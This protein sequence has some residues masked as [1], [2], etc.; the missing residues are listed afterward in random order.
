MKTH[1]TIAGKSYTVSCS[2]ACEIKAQLGGELV[3]LATGEAGVQFCFVSPVGA[4]TSSSDKATLTVNFSA[5]A[6]GGSSQGGK[7]GAKAYM[8]VV[9]L[10]ASPATL[11]LAS[12]VMY[13]CAL[14]DSPDSIYWQ[15]LSMESHPERV[16][17]CE[18]CLD[19][20]GYVAHEVTWPLSWIWLDEQSAPDLSTGGLRYFA[21]RSDHGLS[22]IVEH[23]CYVVANA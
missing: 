18:L 8:P 22:F 9:D 21:I 12:G 10:G 13:R 11:E 23:S 3:L 20:R 2:E 6:L 19:A 4:V 16:M 15:S 7:G 1:K 14:A 5:A 17:T